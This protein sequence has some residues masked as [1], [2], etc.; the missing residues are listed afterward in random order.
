MSEA[1]G[2]SV[3]LM[4]RY[5]KPEERM[6][7]CDIGYNVKDTYLSPVSNASATYGNGNGT[8]NCPGLQVV[9][10]NDGINTL[11]PNIGAYTFIG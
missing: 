10:I 5:L 2:P 7:L 9:G 1:Q 8:S 3:A 4:K 6:V 11:A